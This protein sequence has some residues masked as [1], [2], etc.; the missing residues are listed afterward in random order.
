MEPGLWS[1]RR[2]RGVSRGRLVITHFGS[3]A[4]SLPSSDF[5]CS[6]LHTE[7]ANAF[8]PPYRFWG[9]GHHI[10]IFLHLFPDGT[11]EYMKQPTG[12]AF[13]VPLHSDD[14]AATSLGIWNQPDLL[15][16]SEWI[17]TWIWI[18][19]LLRWKLWDPPNGET[20]SNQKSMRNVLQV[21]S[22]WILHQWVCTRKGRVR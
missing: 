16:S 22:F 20:S 10:T 21:N 12:N 2:E 4:H 8:H 7:A 17:L 14:A 19:S 9:K 13:Q 6:A 11:T 18:P 15:A 3:V 1:E 5:P